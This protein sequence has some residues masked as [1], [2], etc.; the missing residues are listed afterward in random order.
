[1]TIR[2]RLPILMIGLLTRGLCSQGQQATVNPPLPPPVPKAQQITLAQAIGIALQQN[3]QQLA[4][5]HQ[6]AGARAN[7]SGQRAPLNPMIAYAGVN[8]TVTSIDP[9]N[10]DN[11]SLYFTLETSGRQR[12]RTNQARAQL[13]GTVADTQ[14]TRLT[15]R[16]AVASAYIT[17][18]VANS[19]LANERDT[20]ATAQRL[21]D[22]TE[23]Q[24]Q[25]GAASE[26][27]AIRARIAL[28]QEEQNLL[29]AINDVEVARANLNMQMGR[30]PETPVEAAE[31]LEYK[32][33]TVQLETLQRQ[34]MLSRPEVQSAEAGIHALQAAE[35][36]QRSQYY[37]DVTFGTSGKFDQLQLGLTLP[38]FDLGSIRG[39]VR[40]ARE[41]VRVQEA[42]TEQVRQTVQL[43]VQSAYLAF[44]RAQQQVE[45]FQDG[46]LPRAE[47]LLKRI[48]QG[49]AL[50][51]NT[52]LD[53]IDAQNTYRDT[54]NDYYSAIGDYRQAVVQLERAI[55]AP[56]ALAGP[57]K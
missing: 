47:S 33:L 6:V 4:A 25:L 45:S 56:V 37:P 43:D 27:N 10:L 51:A 22:L 36:L 8:N 53:L 42:Q 49:Y 54:R 3:P 57:L 39:A 34:A 11:Y 55:G 20:Y 52:I 2:S 1:M 5:N 17:L 24:F 30:A 48:E 12:L 40:K 16:Q 26:T 9:G 46:I 44:Q 14:T 41:D 23:K 38:L 50:G 28:T 15:V 32:P 21:S 31:P 18:Q 29:K 35:G 13:Q 19:A 7:L